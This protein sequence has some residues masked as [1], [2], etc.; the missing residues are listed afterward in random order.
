MVV[1]DAGNWCLIES[2]PGVFTDLI[3]RFGVK[4]VQVEELW[5]LDDE[6]FSNL[7]PVHGLIFLF[8]WQQEDQPSGTVV[9][10]NRL[11]KIFF[12]KQGSDVPPSADQ[13][14]ISQEKGDNDEEE[15]EPF[16]PEET[17]SSQSVPEDKID[18]EDHLEVQSEG[19][20][21]QSAAI[22]VEEEDV[23]DPSQ[24]QAAALEEET[25]GKTRLILL[26]SPL[27]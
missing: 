15:E 20:E 14:E 22:F 5:S 24:G 1:S 6:S 3:N 23:N 8:K 11:D 7:K 10:D 2:D 18:V 13:E 21:E 19:E 12:A 17:L 26:T 16:V 27:G 25:R 9:Q 4:G